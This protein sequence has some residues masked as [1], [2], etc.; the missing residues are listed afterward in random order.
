M[1]LPYLDD[2]FNN[3]YSF[4]K[5]ALPDLTNKNNIYSK[6]IFQVLND[7]QNIDIESYKCFN[8]LLSAVTEFYNTNFSLNVTEKFTDLKCTWLPILI[9]GSE[10]NTI[11]YHL[12]EFNFHHKF[13]YAQ[14]IRLSPTAQRKPVTVSFTLKNTIT[15][16]DSDHFKLFA[17]YIKEDFDIPI[18]YDVDKEIIYLPGKNNFT[19]STENFPNLSNILFGQ[20][21]HWIEFLLDMN[22]FFFIDITYPIRKIDATPFKNII[23]SI[24]IL[25][26]HN[27][28]FW[29][30]NT[31]NSLNQSI[32]AI[33][34][35]LHIPRCSIFVF[36]LSALEYEWYPFIDA[37]INKLFV[38][39]KDLLQANSPSE[40]SKESYKYLENLLS[41][42]ILLVKTC[43]IRKN[44][45]FNYLPLLF[46]QSNEESGLL[47]K[48]Y[49]TYDNNITN[50]LHNN[51]SNLE[52]L[53][54]FIAL[55]NSRIDS[56]I[57]KFTNKQLDEGVNR[58]SIVVKGN[59]KKDLLH[60]KSVSIRSVNSLL[61]LLVLNIKNNLSLIDKIINTLLGLQKSSRLFFKD[62]FFNISSGNPLDKK[63]LLF[64]FSAL[65]S[66]D[67]KSVRA[68]SL[69]AILYALNPYDIIY[70]VSNNG[71]YDDYYAI[72]LAINELS[73]YLSIPD[74][75]Q[76][77]AEDY[78]Y[79]IDSKLEL[80]IQK[81]IK[82]HLDLYK[83]KLNKFII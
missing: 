60:F 82:E 57:D 23:K 53:H 70:D 39:N 69:S 59:S 66:S 32:N 38:N 64:L 42:V 75:I 12:L 29:F 67:S 63:A 25:P 73:K 54:S 18:E 19:I 51:I 8:S 9:V 15:N 62:N 68:T 7:L 55:M 52:Y 30:C 83:D 77:W 4:L 72:S 56:F 16:V 81:T 1:T 50:I 58:S 5:Y 40:L 31:S 74:D 11:L 34:D 43:D 65:L 26:K 79:N 21:P 10:W 35:L 44:A 20:L 46:K 37:Y 17:N 13:S 22:A 3:T 14:S 6:L 47:V 61:N 80:H 28:N 24:L 2:H 78:V 48:N 33:Y 36:I 45:T 27:S 71:L 41:R 76:K 49:F